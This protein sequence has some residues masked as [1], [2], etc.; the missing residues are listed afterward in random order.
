MQVFP[1]GVGKI[2]TDPGRFALRIDRLEGRIG[3]IH[4]DDESS[5]TVSIG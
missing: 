5:G 2:D 4:A 3:K 1:E